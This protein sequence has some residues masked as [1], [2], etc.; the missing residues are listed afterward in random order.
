MYH[1]LSQDMGNLN[2]TVFTSQQEYSRMDNL[3][4]AALNEKWNLNLSVNKKHDI[5]LNNQWKVI[6]YMFYMLSYSYIANCNRLPVGSYNFLS[7][8]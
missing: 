2:V 4:C 8:Q 3:V 1:K 7:K 5:I 6:S